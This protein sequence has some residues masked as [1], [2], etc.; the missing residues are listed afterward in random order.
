ME[1]KLNVYEM[2]VKLYL[3]QD[4]PFKELQNAVANFVDSALC[5]NES[6]ISFHE[7]NCYKFY[8]VGTLW[9][10]ERGMTYKKDQIYTLTVRTV[11]PILFYLIHKHFH[12]T[13]YLMKSDTLFAVIHALIM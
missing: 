9:P 2:R 10:L 4:I 13:F 1:Q 3:L 5:Q 6:L 12:F 7:T 11:E 8:S